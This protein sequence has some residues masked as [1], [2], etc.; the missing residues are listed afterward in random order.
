MY[1]T[2]NSTVANGLMVTECGSTYLSQEQ[3][4]NPDLQGSALIWLSW[5]LI[6]VRI[7]NADP[8]QERKLAK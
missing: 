8:D 1:Q 5:I 7:G 2:I 4:F 3:S 6:P